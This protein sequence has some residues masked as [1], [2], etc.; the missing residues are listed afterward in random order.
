M[1][2]I[3]LIYLIVVLSI[4]SFS[5]VYVYKNNVVFE[6]KDLTASKVFLA[7][8]FNNWDPTAQPMKK[9]KGGLW[10]VVLRL[11]PGDYQYKFVINGTDWKEDPE[12][13]D[14]VPDGYG[15]KN[16][17]FSLVLE[18]GKLK[19]KKPEK[20]ESGILSGKYSF[21]LKSKVNMDTYS[22]KSPEISH[23]FYLTINPK[24]SGMNFEAVLN[25]DNSNW[26]LGISSI[27]AT[28]ENSNFIFGVF[29]DIQANKLLNFSERV[30]EN[31]IGFFGILKVGDL[32]TGVD[33]YSQDN[34]LKYF[35]SSNIYLSN[36]L[37]SAL[38]MPKTQD[39]SMN[40]YSRIEGFGIGVEAKYSDKIE[41]VKG[42]YNSEILALEGTYDFVNKNIIFGGNY[43]DII[44]FSGEYSLENNVYNIE[45]DLLF[46]IKSGFNVLI[47]A[48]YDNTNN[49]GYKL[50]MELNKD[51][52]DLK[53]KIGNDFSGDFDDYYL[54][55]ASSAIF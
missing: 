36:I 1:K 31:K 11:T 49:F 42:D 16:G 6:F 24:K 45:S 47:D 38:Y 7:G 12:A 8:S 22:F 48:Y 55:I 33:I 3:L 41:Y 17:A 14:Y 37:L 29:K 32:K 34:E 5:K 18:N 39:A 21:D 46:S 15:G 40:I 25:A 28:W 50:G 27:K 26:Q 9:V 10:R 35:V 19:I 52:I 43:D 30:E 54:F 2:K 4:M 23:N 20:Q 53:L 44:T 51:N 13:P